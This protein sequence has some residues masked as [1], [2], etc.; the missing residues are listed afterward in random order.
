MLPIAYP[1][2]QQDVVFPLL[3]PLS[4]EM[5]DIV[6]QCPPQRALAEEDCLDKHSS[7]TDLTQRS[8]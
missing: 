3:V 8:S 4:M 7:L 2:K 6:A 1:R 5:V